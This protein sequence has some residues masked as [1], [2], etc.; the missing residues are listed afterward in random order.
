MRLPYLVLM[1]L[2]TETTWS[3]TLS[4]PKI[5]ISGITLGRGLPINTMFTRRNGTTDLEMY[6][7]SMV[8][9]IYSS[10]PL[11]SRCE[12]HS[13]LHPPSFPWL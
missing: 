5:G 13:Q 2:T 8:N 1:S 12:P 7:V 9:A 6:I 10:I 11:V 4:G 3:Y